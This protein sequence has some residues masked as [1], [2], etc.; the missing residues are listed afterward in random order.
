MAGN[1]S[2]GEILCLY[3]SGCCRGKVSRDK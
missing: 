3:W 2:D 1:K